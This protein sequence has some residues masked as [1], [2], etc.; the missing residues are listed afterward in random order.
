MMRTWFASFGRWWLVLFGGVMLGAGLVLHGQVA[1]VRAM[2]HEV[3]NTFFLWRA[4]G[5]A[6]IFLQGSDVQ[7]AMAMAEVSPEVLRESD[8]AAW[9]LV[10][11]GILLALAGPMLP[12]R[13][14]SS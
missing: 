8:F 6:T 7:M 12:R 11:V 10:V 3:H 13:R 14:V 5:H 2:T 1:L 4:I 9:T